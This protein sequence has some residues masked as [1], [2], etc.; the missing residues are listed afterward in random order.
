MLGTDVRMDAFLSLLF[1]FLFWAETT[2][3]DIQVELS[4]ELA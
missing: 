4:I 3:L 1:H 2:L